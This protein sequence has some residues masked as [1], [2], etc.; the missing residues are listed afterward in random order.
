MYEKLP[1]IY[2]LPWSYWASCAGYQDSMGFS[3]SGSYTPQTMATLQG[4]NTMNQLIQEVFKIIFRQNHI[5]NACLPPTWLVWAR[6]PSPNAGFH[7][8]EGYPKM[9]GLWKIIKSNREMDEN[10]RCLMTLETT[11]LGVYGFLCFFFFGVLHRINGD[12]ETMKPWRW[13]PGC[14]YQEMCPVQQGRL[15]RHLHHCVGAVLHG[16]TPAALAD[17]SHW[18]G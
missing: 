6:T 5:F 9:V 7:K 13:L 18:R 14:I 10:W 11:K 2:C 1:W 8:M 17:Q 4:T 12:G 16:Q 3:E 15:R